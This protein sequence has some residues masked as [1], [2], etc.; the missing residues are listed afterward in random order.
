[1][2]QQRLGEL[3]QRLIKKAILMYGRIKPCGF[4]KKLDDC[5][6]M[7]DNSLCFWFVTED[8]NTHMLRESTTNSLWSILAE[9]TI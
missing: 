2:D 6:T 3:K 7:Q 9:R 8:K 1:M 4:C 5:F